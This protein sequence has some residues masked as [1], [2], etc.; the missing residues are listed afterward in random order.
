MNY[1]YA[2]MTSASLKVVISTLS[3]KI[4]TNKQIFFIFSW[5]LSRTTIVKSFFNFIIFL[6][7]K[8]CEI[9]LKRRSWLESTAN[10]DFS[11]FIISKTGARFKDS[12]SERNEYIS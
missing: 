9:Y 2:R 3:R 10:I 11:L 5:I 4:L 6:H 7:N 12:Y 8:W 1:L